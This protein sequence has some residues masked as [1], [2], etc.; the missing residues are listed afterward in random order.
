[1]EQK[2]IISMEKMSVCGHLQE[3]VEGFQRAK[4]TTMRKNSLKPSL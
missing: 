4:Y 3:K 2:I 1:M